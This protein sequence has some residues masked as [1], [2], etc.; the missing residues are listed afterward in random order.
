METPID[1][2]DYQQLSDGVRWDAYQKQ[3]AEVERLNLELAQGK[4]RE[5]AVCGYCSH[6]GTLMLAEIERLRAIVDQQKEV[7]LQIA[8][9]KNGHCDYTCHGHIE[10]VRLAREAAEAGGK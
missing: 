6:S 4:F 5:G 10:A 9:T 2:E 1:W 3:L 8:K 7:L